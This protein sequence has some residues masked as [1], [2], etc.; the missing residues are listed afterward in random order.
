M[1]EIPATDVTVIR[2]E[3]R[4]ACSNQVNK[5]L[6][7]YIGATKLIACSEDELL[8]YIKSVAVKVT[9]KAVHRV[10]FDKMIQNDGEAITRYV[11]RLKAKA[12]LCKFEI[13]CNCT[14]PIIVSYAEERVSER[15]L[16]GLQNKAH[17]TIH[18]NGYCK[19]GSC[20]RA[21]KAILFVVGGNC[22]CNRN[23]SHKE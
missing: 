20:N 8:S 5:L 12:S 16:A 2:N 18:G 14:P 13:N 3:L 19:C 1:L 22:G 6:F 10:E 4:S 7:E 9:H 15:L 21:R 17:Q 11:S 23:C